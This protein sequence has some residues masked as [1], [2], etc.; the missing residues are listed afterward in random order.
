M[1]D[2]EN[3]A[4]ERQLGKEPDFEEEAFALKNKVAYDKRM[5]EIARK[6]KKFL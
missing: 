1:L 4:L 5:N 6:R 3:A 2:Q